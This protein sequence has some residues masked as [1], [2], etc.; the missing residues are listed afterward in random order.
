MEYTKNYIDK[1]F[2]IIN[3]IDFKILDEI[4]EILFRCWNEGNKVFILG[5][6]GSASTA[7]HMACDLSKGTIMNL[8]DPKLKR[9]KVIS[10]TDNIALMTAIGNDIGYNEIFSQQLHL[11]KEEDALIVITG[12]GNS[13]NVI[14]AVEKGNNLGMT[15]IGMLGFDGGKVKD[16][17]DYKIILPEN[18]Y[19]R[20]EDFHLML[21]HIITEQLFNKINSK[22]E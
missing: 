18:H 9:L 10:I 7:S 19:G 22:D 6:G 5:N 11:A 12:S 8:H 3:N 13:E 4:I 15:T 2:Q 20:V 16:M 21:N 14:K 1:Y 17:L